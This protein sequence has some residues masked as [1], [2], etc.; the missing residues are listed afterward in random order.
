MSDFINRQDAIYALTEANLKSHMDSVEGGQ[1]NRSAIRIIM[2]L[3]TA[4]VVEV[5]RCKD[6]KHY[7]KNIS[8]VGGMH[9][10]CAEWLNE[11]NETEVK[12]YD[13]CSFGE[14]R[15]DDKGISD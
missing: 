11:G 7:R 14:R 5:V 1:E 13:Y 8:C 12:E 10:G 15:E 6:C 9:N 4:D 2:E 3:P